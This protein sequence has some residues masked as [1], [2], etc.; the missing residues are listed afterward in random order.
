[1]IYAPRQAKAPNAG[2][3][4]G[5]PSKSVVFRAKAPSAAQKPGQPRKSAALRAKAWNSEQ[6]PGEWSNYDGEYIC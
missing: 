3:K 6:K 2:K 1:V 4:G 5:V